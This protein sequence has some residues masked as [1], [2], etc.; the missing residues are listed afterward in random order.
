M[1]AFALPIA[2]EVVGLG[3]LSSVAATERRRE[4]QVR[5]ALSV[6]DRSTREVYCHF[7][8]AGRNLECA[9]FAG[10]TGENPDNLRLLGET[11]RDWLKAGVPNYLW[12]E[13]LREGIAVVLVVD[14]R[15]AK[16]TIT[17][18]GADH[19]LS[20]TVAKLLEASTTPTVFCDDDVLL[21]RI[22]QA[23]GEAQI[24]RR[25]TPGSVLDATP[26]RTLVEVRRIPAVVRWNRFRRVVQNVV[27]LGIVAAVAV[28]VYWYFTKDVDEAEVFKSADQ[29]LLDE[30]NQ[31]LDQPDPA[32]VIAGIH[33]AYLRATEE[34]TY[35]NVQWLRWQPERGVGSD[36]R[37]MIGIVSVGAAL[38]LDPETGE[39]IPLTDREA[40]EI[41]EWTDDRARALG[42]NLDLVQRSA[43]NPRM[44]FEAEVPLDGVSTRSPDEIAAIRRPE[45]PRGDSW[46]WSNLQQDFELVTELVGTT[47]SRRAPIINRIYRTRSLVVELRNVEWGRPDMANWLAKRLGGGPVML[48]SVVVVMDTNA[49]A[50]LQITFKTAWCTPDPGTG[51]CAKPT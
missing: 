6:A 16:D 28:G 9:F 14:G 4:K 43:T 44:K 35:W 47:R 46:H 50:A 10:P 20:I 19:E 33:A 5:S 22:Q 36:R 30:Y 8:R 1:T 21:G 24:L 49:L 39:F 12:C 25:G 23:A 32:A 18:E 27:M 45:P 31:M 34:F 15:V 2:R 41:A 51:D 11:V 42:W 37:N 48:E 26:M 38:P 17:D 3:L 40:I 29:R 7:R 13:R